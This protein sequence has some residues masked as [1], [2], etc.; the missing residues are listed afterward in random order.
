MA[1]EFNL[2][3]ELEKALKEQLDPKLAKFEQNHETAIKKFSSFKIKVM[4]DLEKIRKKKANQDNQ[5]TKILESD[6][7]KMPM[8]TRGNTV[9]N[10]ATDAAKGT[11][12]G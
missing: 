1:E 3:S 5:T 10:G 11:A 2:K 4:E 6:P 8:R 9:R 12:L 7:S